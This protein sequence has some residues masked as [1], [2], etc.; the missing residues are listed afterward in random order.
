MR[1][2]PLLA[3]S[4][5]GFDCLFSSTRGGVSFWHADGDSNVGDLKL[6]P[7]FRCWWHFLNVK[8]QWMLVTQMAIHSPTSWICYQHIS[9]PTFVIKIDVTDAKSQT[10]IKFSSDC[11]MD[12][13]DWLERLYCE[14][15]E[16]IYVCFKQNTILS[17]RELHNLLYWTHCRKNNVCWH[18]TLSSAG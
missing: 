13:L 12:I 7:A 18:R 14:S 2:Q 15:I 10:F 9:S 11:T 5:F 8:I 6:V 17:L 3:S 4:T 16:S 1:L